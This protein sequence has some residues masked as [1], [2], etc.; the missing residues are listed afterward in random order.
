MTAEVETPDVEMVWKG[1]HAEALTDLTTRELA[2]EGAIRSGK[3]TVCLWRELNAALAHPGIAI[4][5]ARQTDG[6]LYG[7]IARL[8]RDMCVQV[9]VRLVWNATVECDQLPNGSTV[10]YRALKSQDVT[11]RY[12]K[13]RGLTIARAYIDQAE[14]IDHDVYLELA[15]RLSQPGYSHQIT[16]SPQSAEHGSWLEKEFPEDNRFLPNRKLIQ[17][18]IFDN[19]HNLPAGT[20]EANLRLYPP[21]HPKHR[22]MILGQRGMN[23][24]GE[25]V[26]GGVFVRSLHEQAAGFDPNLALD[27]GID[28]GKHHPCVVWRQTSALGQ[29]RYLG[30]LLG[31]DMYLEDFLP[32]VVQYRNKWFPQPAMLRM[33][34]DPSGDKDTSHGT[35]GGADIIKDLIGQRPQCVVGSNSPSVRTTVI[36]RLAGHMRRRTAGG[37]EAFVIAKEDRWLRLSKD[38]VVIDRFL[39]DGFEAGYVWGEHMVSDGRKQY[40][41]PKKDGWYEHGQNCAEYLEV[42]FGAVPWKAKPKAET[43]RS[44]YMG[45]GTWAG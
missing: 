34:C 3:T 25:P 43:R 26:Y 27:E 2:I 28:F 18:S 31:Q 45:E 14:E 44:G 21:E 10:Y 9:G 37:A 6:P 41:V 33:C 24:T 38:N 23:V 1:K 16:I 12:A 7:L 11:L 32:L 15:G 30:G 29:V 4:L 13:I 5:F 20:V 19:A 22:T 40:R 39:A 17:L 8:W 35:K 36:E 42:N